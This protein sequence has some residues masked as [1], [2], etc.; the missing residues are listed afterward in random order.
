[1]L[2]SSCQTFRDYLRD[3]VLPAV[4]DKHGEYLLVELV[5]Q[6]EHH[7]IMNKWMFRFFMYLVRARVPVRR[8]SSRCTLTAAAKY[9]CRTATIAST[10]VCRRWRK[11]V[12]GGGDVWHCSILSQ[13]AAR[14]R[15]LSL[16]CRRPRG[17]P[18]GALRCGKGEGGKGD[19]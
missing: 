5:K 8:P 15:W 18:G 19:D 14:Y 12:R 4:R 6:W 7:K 1:L 13:R 10:T 2:S 11:Q 16:F 3:K 9:A 17:V